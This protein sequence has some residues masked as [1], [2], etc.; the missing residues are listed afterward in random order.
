MAQTV[1]KTVHY[2]RATITGGANLQELLTEI[3]IPDGQAY[4]ASSR[5]ETVNASDGSFRVI[6]HNRDYSG[7][8]FCQMIYFE[9]GKSQAFI[10]L[11]EDATSYTVDAF[12]NDSL[13]TFGTEAT[14]EQERHRREFVD[15]L[16]YFGVFENH[17]VLLQ[18][19]ALRS[20]ELEAH[21]GW[22]I[23]AF[24]AD[25]LVTVILSDQPS[26]ETYEKLASIPVKKVSIGTPIQTECDNSEERAAQLPSQGPD[27]D[28]LDARRVRFYPAGRAADLISAAMGGDWLNKLDLNED[29]D[30]ANLQVSLEITYVRRTTK[31][32]QM[33]IDNLAT[34][35]RHLDESD[36]RVEL[37]GGGV[38]RGTDLKMSGPITASKLDNGL[39]DEGVLY[40]KMHAWLVSKLRNGAADAEQD[41]GE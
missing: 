6:N 17:V 23:G 36:V 12:T 14:R 39:M 34:S 15:S 4:K 30:D 16:L 9:P 33:I 22:L 11:D 40:H 26:Q 29:L 37:K 10:T 19:S 3:L 5:K 1:S 25:P 32:G 21:L 13:N 31:A 2:K 18:Y 35:L 27:E 8:L 28:H 41:S 7:V 24:G 38:L 20:R